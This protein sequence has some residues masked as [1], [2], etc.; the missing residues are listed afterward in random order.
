MLTGTAEAAP[1]THAEP[2][3][4]PITT[5]R[6]GGLHLQFGADPSTE[7]VVS[8]HTRQPVRRPRVL[9]GGPDGNFE[10]TAAA[11]TSSYTDAKSGQVVYVHHAK[12][13]WLRPGTEY[14]YAAVHEGAD[15]EFGTFH[16]APKGRAKFT[17][18]SFG[19]QGT[20]TLGKRYVPPPGTSIANPP[21]VNDNLGSP[22]A[23][24]V[25]AGV[26][27]VRPLFHLFNGDL[28][29]ANLSE[30]RVR[31]WNDFWENNTRSA[32]NRPWMPAAGNH[33]NELGN[34]PIGYEAYQ[35]YFA[36]P[37]QQ[38]QTD[39]TRGL[40]YAFTVGSVR[41]ISLAND[42]V[43]YQDGGNSYIRGYSQG[44]QKEW[45]ERELKATRASRDIDWI[46]VCMHQ[47]VVSS[48]DQANG[49]DLGIR[50]EWVPLFDEYG[51]DLVVCGHEHHY[52]RSHPIRGQQRNQTLTP[53]PASTNASVAD[54][55]KGTVHMVIGGGG[56]SVGSNG[57][58]FNPPAC[59]VIT[60]VGAPDSVTGKRPPVY[61]REDAPWSAARNAAH[62][63][64]FA[65]FT[66]DPGT[67]GGSTTMH[68]TY[69]DVLGPAGEL[70]VFESFTLTRP[71]ND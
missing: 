21:Y 24:D 58:L 29:Y 39:V 11:V 19:D 51:V 22:A 59:R 65:A 56:T 68:V 4:D 13:G 43:C 71:R 44:A 67:R 38:G 48:A 60:A 55:S 34:G 32:R 62:P 70:S 1:V 49:A 36:L 14:V 8:W 16:T 26:E 69:Y 30:D 66:V 17:F 61:V 25:T 37:R 42:D 23:G 54:T 52:E 35:T 64:G 3:A 20:P 12:A 10:R 33:E 15:A 5:P 57:V 28:C 45:L 40:W 31:T 41:V 2:A 6:V 53:I 63:Y 50:Q 27:R 7:L 18:T 47:V 46:V 9:L